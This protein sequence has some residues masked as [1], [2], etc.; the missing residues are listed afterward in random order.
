M[1]RTA[2]LAA[3]LLAAR[4]THCSDRGVPLP[5]PPLLLRLLIVALSPLWCRHAAP[6]HGA[7]SG[8]RQEGD[9]GVAGG[10][11]EDRLLPSH[12]KTNLGYGINC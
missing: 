1:L 3:W 10:P 8:W 11:Y 4:P 5:P 7:K 2:L 9:A 12:G 6:R